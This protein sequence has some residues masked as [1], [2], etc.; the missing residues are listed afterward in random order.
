MSTR[1]VKS[2]MREAAKLAIINNNGKISG[3]AF[4]EIV[5]YAKRGIF[6]SGE[7][8]ALLDPYSYLSRARGI[9]VGA[10]S[11]SL[12]A[13]AIAASLAADPSTEIFP[14]FTIPV[15]VTDPTPVVPQPISARE[16]YAQTLTSAK[17]LGEFTSW[18]LSTPGADVSF[19]TNAAGRPW[20]AL[21][22][23][24]R[25]FTDPDSPRDL[26]TENADTFAA[27]TTPEEFGAAVDGILEKEAAY[28]TAE[29]TTTKDVNEAFGV[30]N[31]RRKS[32]V[33]G[34]LTKAVGNT[35][36]SFEDRVKAQ[37]IARK[38]G[39]TLIDGV[40]FNMKVGSHT[41][42]WPYWNNYA[43]PLEKMLEQQ[44][45]GSPEYFQIKNR[46]NDIYRRKTSNDSRRRKINERDF[47]ASSQMAL[48]YNPQFTVGSGHR[49][50]TTSASTPFSPSYELLSVKSD[51]LP[52]ELQSYAG[53]QVYRDT[54][55]AATL[56]F[57]Y[58]GDD[59]ES[60]AG[61]ALPEGLA[62]HINAQALSSGQL[63]GLSLRNF[64][65]SEK[66]RTKIA[67]D[68][69][70]NG[71]IDI[72]PTNIGWWGHCHNEAPLNAMG[73]DPQKGVSYYRATAG[74]NP[75]KALQEYSAE[76]AWDIAGAF[77]ADHEGR[78]EWAIASTGNASYNVDST[79]FIGHR[80]DGSHKLQLT[81]ANGRSISV[82][83]ELTS[84]TTADGESQ[85]AK[86]VFRESI[87]AED[88]TF[89]PNPLYIST[90]NNDTVTIDVQGSKMALKNEYFTFDSSGYPQKKTGS[91]TLDPAKDEFIKISEGISNRLPGVGG[92]VLEHYF[93]AKT[94]QYKSATVSYTKEN[95]FKAEQVSTTDP[96]AVTSTNHV[97][98]TQ[99]DSAEAVYDYFMDN[100]GLP[101]TY[102]TSSGK[103]VWNYPIY[104]EKLDVVKEVT[105]DE[106]GSTYTYRTLRLAYESMGGPNKTQSFILKYDE[107][108][109]VVD[110]CALDPMPDFAFRNDHWVAAPI[111][112]DSRG[113][114]AFNVMAL[115]KGYLIR[116]GGN[117]IDDIETALW[118][119]EAAL[120]YASLT[121]ATPKDHAYI[122]ETA[123]G[124][125]LSFENKSDFD[126]AVA[127]HKQINE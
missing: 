12:E 40:D 11:F 69:G 2:A 85:N 22:L 91:V 30:R 42:Y 25:T 97:T 24:T 76:D 93:N 17:N 52:E 65:G 110:S 67:M 46:L 32:F 44:T 95:E 73:I 16:A 83:G 58:V 33:A 103:A 87:E 29:T 14:N 51:G 19:S 96:V 81:L 78:P 114:T 60:R 41:N 54:D 88:G 48:V 63:T 64:K 72:A 118:K 28:F 35:G 23:D 26:I 115:N 38:A 8:R 68:W 74:V 13:R 79:S 89:G 105:K 80:N 122:L 6:T 102:D 124:T 99:Y 70:S 84:L 98:E 61:T 18:K 21:V 112:T 31:I 117:S 92:E 106:D 86:G 125:F 36:L 5:T 27:C 94:G 34:L 123:D 10:I 50:S 71:S 47:E 45:E 120:L 49:V 75:A 116:Q 56:R 9:K 4:N 39:I 101:K 59:T 55:E 113:R 62:A 109:T 119:T 3:D 107:S 104:R 121:E 77:T 1:G 7:R 108:G 20:P 53:T 90:T 111:T 127:A 43:A 126:K 100:P 66:A 15:P 37:G 57:D 82:D